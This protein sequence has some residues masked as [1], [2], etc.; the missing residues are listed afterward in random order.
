MKIIFNLLFFLLS[1]TVLGQHDYHG[2]HHSKNKIEHKKLTPQQKLLIQNSNARSDTFDVFHYD[3]SID[4]TN[5]N[6][7]F[8]N[9][10]T[11]IIVSPKQEGLNA[12]N[13]DLF[14]LEVDSVLFNGDQLVF[15]NDTSNLNI[16]FNSIP[17]ITDT[18]ALTVYYHGT[19]HQ[20]DNWGGFYFESGYIYNLG[21]GLSTIPPNFGKVWYPCF[22][23]FVE[24]ATYSYH[25]KSA[26]GRIAYC[27]GE[28]V[29]EEILAGDTLI[30]HF[31]FNQSIP[32]FLSA[33]AVA[34]YE[35]IAYTHPGNN[36]NIPITLT[37]KAASMANM[38][39]LFATLGD[40]IDALEYWYGPYIWG[41][42]GYVLTTDGALE[43]P[44]NIAYPASMMGASFFNNEQLFAHELGHQ[45]WG[46]VVTPRLHNH[47]WIKEGPA[48]YSGHLFEEWM[49]GEE[50]FL[51]LVKDNLLFV[52]ED[53]HVDDEGFW[54]LSPIPDEHIYGRHTYYKGAAVM[55]NLR[56][57][58]GDSL[59]RQTMTQVQSQ[60]AFTD[61][62]AEA[63]KEAMQTVSGAD[64]NPF[65]T[66]QI[67]SPG[68][69]TFV[70]DSF[71]SLVNSGGFETTVF[72]QQKL[73]EC[74]SF[75]TN[76]PVEIATVNLDWSREIFSGIVSG[77]YDQLVIQTEEIPEFIIFNPRHKL[78]GAR[79]DQEGVLLVDE[80]Y[81]HNLGHVDMRI[82][83]IEITDSSLIHVAHI[84]SA[85]EVE[86]GDNV[87]EISTTHYWEV[88]GIWND[89]ANIEARIYYDGNS[90]GDLDVDLASETEEGLVPLYREN[91]DMLWQAYSDIGEYQGSMENGIGNYKLFNL[92]KGQYAFGRIMN[93]S[94]IEQST[95]DLTFNIF[96]N[97]SKDYLQL[98]FEPQK[99]WK[100]C[101][102]DNLGRKVIDQPFT[103]KK[104]VIEHLK[105]GWY[106][107]ILYNEN[108]EKVIQSNVEIIK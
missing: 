91:S 88:D 33:I 104:I 105:S 31:D 61:V 68:F 50:E 78:N 10:V 9:A 84:W 13:F 100:V 57:Y 95:I 96:P 16:Q 107:L 5:Y 77:E 27:Q 65:F 74:P 35:T 45:W 38:E 41:K 56:A 108:K 2:C 83:K 20:D 44:T 87:I 72:L 3:I 7:E 59:F 71:A 28:L 34:E 80:T 8:I 43:I 32:T 66:D 58:L 36:G 54:P 51:D 47:M 52:L 24:R 18:L 97:P 39:N 15:S 60:Y 49:A 42:V 17:A 76:V 25:I 79:L 73:R 82:K 89:N 19:P 70:V 103:S 101:L 64:L 12:I 26:D 1:F 22:D 86:L 21:I 53:A 67:Y 6:D 48:E 81:N 69:S 92:Q 23:S 98:D 55:H 94:I 11:T 90:A 93:T 106:S 99:E 46:N 85:P 30:R 29:G 63:F 40:A 37:G 75:H 102:F 4:V 62:D 14:E